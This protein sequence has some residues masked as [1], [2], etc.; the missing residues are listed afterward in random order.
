ML[1]SHKNS[2]NEKAQRSKQRELQRR[3]DQPLLYF[4][5]H[6]FENLNTNNSTLSQ[7]NMT[8]AQSPSMDDNTANATN[9]SGKE[10]QQQL[11]AI[12]NTA[13]KGNE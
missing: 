11:K 7:L 3:I 13:Q 4:Y 1:I 5:S 12:I 8:L 10:D 2:N 6:E 9:S